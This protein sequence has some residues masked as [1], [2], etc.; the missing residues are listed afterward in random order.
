MS[1]LSV[2]GVYEKTWIDPPPALTQPGLPDTRNEVGEPKI[3]ERFPC[4]SQYAKF[5]ST[6]NRNIPVR[7]LIG[8]VCGSAIKTECFGTTFPYVHHTALGWSFVGPVGQSDEHSH[9]TRI[10]RT[11]SHPTSSKQL[12]KCHM[13]HVFRVKPHS[14]NDVFLRE[15]S[16]KELD[17]SAVDKTFLELIS[18]V[19]NNSQGNLNLPLPF[20]KGLSLP[21]IKLP[22]YMRTRNSFGRINGGSELGIKCR[23]TTQAY[24]DKGQV[25][26]FNEPLNLNRQGS[27][28]SY[29]PVIPV[30]N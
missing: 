25:S 20:K 22:V 18:Q 28:E 5:F 8:T 14:S 9:E 19:S 29:L 10:L 16:D 1:N 7:T 21:Q 6:V 11:S 13:E 3:V 17:V 26:H 4:L 2:R 15:S 23:E 30:S 27:N 12:T 24:I